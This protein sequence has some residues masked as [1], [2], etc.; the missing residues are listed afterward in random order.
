MTPRAPALW[1]NGAPVTYAQLMALIGAGVALFKQRGVLAGDR[2][3]IVAENCVAEIALLFAVSELGAWP[4]VLNARMSAREIE[5]IR[6]HSR[7]R[8]QVFT[9]A[10]SPDAAAHARHVGAVSVISGEFKGIDIAATDANVA[11]EPGEVA[12]EVATLI[13]TSGTTGAPKGVMVT[14]R[15][16]LHFCR[17]SSASRRLIPEDRV[18]AVLP[19]SHIFGIATV[20]LTTLYAGAS[21]WVE[22]RF[23]AAAM[24]NALSRRDISILQGV[25]IMFRRLLAHL[26][27]HGPVP[28]FPRLRYLYT[29]GGSLDPGLKAE[30]EAAFSLPLHLGYGMTEYAGS[31]F[32]TQMDRPRRD[33]SSG[34]LNAGCEVRIVDEQGADV[35]AAQVGEIWVRGPGTM[36]GYYRAPE[37]TQEVMLAAGWLKTGDLGRL[38]T[39]GA[40]FIVGRRK[41]LIKRSGFNVYPAEVEA[42]LNT[43]PA[44]KLS[45]VIGCPT[46]DGNENVVAFVEIEPG[47]AFDALEIATFAS[48]QLAPYK[49]PGEIIPIE[50]LP[51]NANGKVR[52]LELQ[53]RCANR[54]M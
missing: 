6:A 11:P 38:E 23:D 47:A 29:G 4:I 39:D 5:E 10:I 33:C 52:K 8:L 31:M 25:P 7:P 26:R 14:H 46:S 45:A 22:P 37:L 50:A 20:V 44:V 2:V 9:S 54:G 51:V 48:G 15:G 49:R 13:Y 32:V 34:M 42:V 43:L 1:E 16:L 40:L 12:Q 28:Q 24:V 41:E 53:S 27:E 3:I 36:L 18:Y 30:V 35:A 19:V 21:I 17:V